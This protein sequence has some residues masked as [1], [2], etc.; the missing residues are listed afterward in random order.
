[1]GML[2]R[3]KPPSQI[4]RDT[5]ANSVTNITVGD[6]IYALGSHSFGLLFIVIALPLIIP[7]PPGIGFI[8][9]LLLLVLALQR[10]LGRSRLW[11]PKAI[12]R[13]KVSPKILQKIDTKA[14]PLYEKVE[15][16]CSKKNRET[17]DLYEMEIR[18]ASMV[19]VL[20]SALMMLPTPF[21]NTIPAIIT[22]IMGLAILNSNR[23][24]LWINMIFG[25]LALGLI[26]STIFVGAELLLEEINDFIELNPI[27]RD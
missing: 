19:V 26:G 15:R 5:M 20:M 25:V 9:A 14:L 1:M 4:I 22:I 23:R 8:P 10:A 6:I 13:R 17:S 16:Y 2:L 27:S 24:I 21:L 11:F 12:S 18:L 3:A 7:L